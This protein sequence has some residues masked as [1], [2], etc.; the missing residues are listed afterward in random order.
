MTLTLTLNKICFFHEKNCIYQLAFSKA[1]NNNW[2][3]MRGKWNGIQ[4]WSLRTFTWLCASQPECNLGRKAVKNFFTPTRVKKNTESPKI[5]EGEA[6]VLFHSVGRMVIHPLSNPTGPTDLPPSTIPFGGLPAAPKPVSTHTASHLA[7][8]G[9][10]G[11]GGVGRSEVGP[12]L[13]K[14]PGL[15]F[16]A[17]E[18]EI[19][20]SLPHRAFVGLGL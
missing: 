12:F 2:T 16:S 3:R 1:T 9:Q 14:S 10:V 4:T 19:D 6:G 20:L 5:G 11:R 13:T 17:V 18:Q 7:S 8:Q 15:R